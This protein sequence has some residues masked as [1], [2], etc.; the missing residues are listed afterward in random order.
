MQLLLDTHAFLWWQL[1]TDQLSDHAR[2]SIAD[3]SNQVFVSAVSVWEIATKRR[4]GKVAF[5]TSPTGAIGANGFIE[6]PILATDA[7]AAGELD[8][9]HND[10]FDRLLVAQARARGITLVTADAAIRAYSGVAQLA[11]R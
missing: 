6:M 7:E 10:P 8:W 3:R 2:S 5:D 1:A 9:A 4:L 11:A